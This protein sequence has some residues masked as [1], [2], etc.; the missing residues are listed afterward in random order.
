LPWTISP[1]REI[2]SRFMKKKHLWFQIHSYDY[3]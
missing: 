1:S 3:L 2:L